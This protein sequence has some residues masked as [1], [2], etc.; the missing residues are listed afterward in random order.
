MTPRIQANDLKAFGRSFPARELT[1]ELNWQD[2]GAFKKIKVELA[3]LRKEEQSLRRAGKA[4][5]YRVLFSGPPG[6]GKTL[7][8]LLLG[9]K[10]GRRVVYVDLPNLI[11]RYIG[12]TEK[13]LSKL[14]ERAEAEN[15]LLFFDEADALFGKRTEVKDSH[16]RYAN[17]EVSYLLERMERHADL[18]IFSTNARPERNEAL[19]RYFHRIIRFTGDED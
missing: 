4:E 7:A 5:S 14:L 8:A 2:V 1:T 19:R 17:Q 12:E 16:D 3:E 9:Q 13:N 10:N 18:V 11:S 15:W 6:T